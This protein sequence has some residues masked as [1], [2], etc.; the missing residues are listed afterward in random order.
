M[1]V[2]TRFPEAATS[3]ELEGFVGTHR[4]TQL[5]GILLVG[6]LLLEVT[7]AAFAHGA[8]HVQSEGPLQAALALTL[9]VA[10]AVWLWH[11]GLALSA[12]RA[13]WVAVALL[14]ALAVWT[15]ITLAWSLAPD[16]TWVEL[17]RAIAYVV[18]VLLALAA[19]SWHERSLERFAVGY[20]AVAVGVALYALGGKI[21]PGVHIGGLI[22]LNQT[23]VFPRLRA[24]LDYWNALAMIA[25]LGMPIALR[26]AADEARAMVPRLAALLALTVLLVTLGLTYSRGGVVALVV[27][28]VVLLVLTGARLRTL[29]TLGLAVAAAIPALAYAFTHHGLKD[30]LVALSKRERPG[31]VLGL[32]LLA[33]L[34]A[35]AGGGRSLFGAERRV[36]LSPVRARQVGLG[37]ALAVVV[38]LAA[39]IGAATFSHRGLSGTIS[40]QWHSFTA[41]K[42][43]KQAPLNPAHLLSVNSSNRWVWWQEAVGAWYDRPLR[44]WGAGSFPVL[45][46]RYRTNQLTVLQPHSVPL[47]FLAETGLVGALLAMGA[48]LLLAAAAVSVVRTSPPSRRGIAAAL[49]AGSVGWL[50][51]G[52][53]EWDWDIP[54]V[55]LPG[56]IFLGVVA[57]SR[58]FGGSRVR[59]AGSSAR[60]I[61]LGVV[62]LLMSAVAVSALLPAWSD[63][64]TTRATDLASGRPTGTEL[65]RAADK[66]E[67]AA[68]LN[69]L[70]P[71]PLFLAASIAER[72]GRL[73]AARRELVR[74]IAR[75][76]NNVR[77]RYE[78]ARFDGAHG[79]LGV[80]RPTLVAALRL[81]P[82]STLAYNLF[83]TFSLVAVPPNESA[84]ATGT[85][86]PSG[87]LA[88]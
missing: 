65:N 20:L 55:L 28:V 23:S 77:A 8:T 85:P 1:P 76:P 13:A 42:E 52:L 63:Y 2:T 39:G 3:A 29:L 16:R 82:R 32:I 44:G 59:L 49:A 30:S 66:A 14:S 35:L 64:T 27:C 79:N 74:A 71:D 38:A 26:L 15:G 37:L 47:Q 19:G 24:P 46:R 60:M 54:G 88:F 86:L 83:A 36:R 18:V 33:S 58:A 22:D 9:V 69:P 4:R 51:H 67:L 7:Y 11:G 61:G 5:P 53:Y 84:T 56:L 68:R 45:H 80:L 70:S 57:G 25:V 6:A 81:D 87:Q 62:A 12:P 73:Q 48:L 75:A 78:L 21:A 10:A 41:V 17:N 50:V 31:L 43:E 72:R 34:V 40:H